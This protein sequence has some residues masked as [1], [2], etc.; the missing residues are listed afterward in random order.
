MGGD[1]EE[2]NHFIHSTFLFLPFFWGGLPSIIA[3]GFASQLKWLS[4]N[5][6]VTYPLFST[7]PYRFT[8]HYNSNHK[9]IYLYV[10]AF[11]KEA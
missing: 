8:L 10:L 7:L 1:G 3:N 4:Q 11:L 5:I 9:N 6:Y 2:I